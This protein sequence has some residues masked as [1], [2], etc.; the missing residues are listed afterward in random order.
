MKVLHFTIRNDTYKVR[1]NGD[2]TQNHNDWS[3]NWK[4]LGVSYHHWRNGVD[5]TVKE[6]FLNPRKLIGGL[7]WDIDYG[8]TRQWGGQYCGKLPR[9]TNAYIEEGGE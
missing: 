7:V 9:V 4:F 2:I 3:G 6:A 8:T 5:F 1:E